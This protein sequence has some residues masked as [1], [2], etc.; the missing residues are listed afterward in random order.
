MSVGGDLIGNDRGKI[1]PLLTPSLSD[2]VKEFWF[3]L[4][5]FFRKN[6]R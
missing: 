3:N 1:S 5:P 2:V 6:F 4:P